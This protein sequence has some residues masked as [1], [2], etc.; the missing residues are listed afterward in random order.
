MSFAWFMQANLLEWNTVP[1]S[2]GPVANE[3]AGVIEA[4]TQLLNEAQRD[5]NGVVDR[6]E[7]AFAYGQVVA[8]E[9]VL[10]LLRGKKS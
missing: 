4:V 9:Q 2:Q 5:A 7:G 3:M 1:V 8:L 6:E 10:E